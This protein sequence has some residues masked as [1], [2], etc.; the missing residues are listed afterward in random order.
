VPVQA[1][2]KDREVQPQLEP[3][4]MKRARMPCVPQA[5]PAESSPGAGEE[6]GL[7][8]RSGP[9]EPP[10]GGRGLQPTAGRPTG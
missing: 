9:H 5:S 1:D 6:L 8:T 2:I 4:R 7:G 3:G 10:V